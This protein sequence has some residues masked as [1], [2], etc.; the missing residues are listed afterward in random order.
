MLLAPSY[1]D[2]HDTASAQATGEVVKIG[3]DLVKS[4]IANGDVETAK[5][6]SKFTTDYYSSRL[7]ML[8]EEHVPFADDLHLSLLDIHAKIEGDARD[9]SGDPHGSI[10][11]SHGPGRAE[12][13]P[14]PH[15]L[16]A[17]RGRHV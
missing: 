8:R 13:Y 3:T 15:P 17:G 1:A 4:S 11:R 2:S 10:D 12:L 5:K 16:P 9:R 7:L 14:A 6:Y